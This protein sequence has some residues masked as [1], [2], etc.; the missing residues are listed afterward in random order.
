MKN[1]NKRKNI[2]EKNKYFQRKLIWNFLNLKK[3]DKIKIV[4]T[5]SI[6]G[7]VITSTSYAKSNNILQMDIR[8]I[9]EEPIVS[10]KHNDE[11][12]KQIEN[13]E[14][15]IVKEFEINNFDEYGNI[16]VIDSK[17]SLSIEP[18]E[19]EVSEFKLY[20]AVILEENKIEMIELNE[21]EYKN[22]KIGIDINQTDK[23][24]LEVVYNM[25][26]V[27]KLVQEMINKNEIKSENEK[28]R[29]YEMVLA[30]DIKMEVQNA[31]NT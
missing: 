17:Y 27:E 9:I 28:N 12:Q 20:K 3:V 22:I 2:N 10:I 31:I 24:V 7:V 18:R 16:N 5:L 14:E 6:L 8:G 19:K 26:K 21:K 25:E 30:Y 13:I 23:Y 4:T 1:K 15:K 29:I 11:G